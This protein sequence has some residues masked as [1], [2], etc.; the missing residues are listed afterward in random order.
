MQATVALLDLE[1]AAI[2]HVDRVL[3][4]Q[5]KGTSSISRGPAISS[6][7]RCRTLRGLPFGRVLR[8]RRGTGSIALAQRKLGVRT[9]MCTGAE[10]MALVWGLRKAGLSLLTSRKG[11]GQTCGRP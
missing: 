5:T 10:E 11:T 4:D 8:P 7:D 1:P 3:L 6:P 9:Q 2:E